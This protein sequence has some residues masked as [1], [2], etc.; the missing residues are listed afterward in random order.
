M[1]R[2]IK[3]QANHIAGQFN[4]TAIR[5]NPAAKKMFE[6]RRTVRPPSRS[7]VLPTSGP[8]RADKRRANDNAANIAFKEAKF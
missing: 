6:T 4:E 8:T 2:P 3:S 7:M 1:P 5:P